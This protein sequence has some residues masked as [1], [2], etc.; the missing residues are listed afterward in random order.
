MNSMTKK[1]MT[2][3]IAASLLFGAAYLQTN[4][5]AATDSNTTTSTDSSAAAKLQD[6]FHKGPRGHLAGGMHEFNLATATAGLLQIQESELKTELEQGKTLVEIA[7]AK[8][9]PKADYI[10]KLTAAHN[11]KIDEQ[12]S[13]GKLTQEQ[14]DTMKSK[15]VERLTQ[16]VEASHIGRGGMMG[17]GR[18][19]KGAAFGKLGHSGDV[20]EIL[21]VTAEELQAGLKEG[22]SIA[23]IAQ[24]KGISEADLIEKLKEKMTEPLKTWVNQKHA[25]KA[26]LNN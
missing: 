1:M 19:G 10:S 14:A 17:P 26:Q 15:A 13:A 5:Y 16:A 24:S 3:V 6:R 22:K 23:E 2:G 9:L 21:N 4:A 12:V 20:A 25:P 11:Q 7:E 18:H 8:G